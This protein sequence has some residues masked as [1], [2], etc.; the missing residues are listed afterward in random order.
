VNKKSNLKGV[1]RAKILAISAVLSVVAT[2]C[3]PLTD[4]SV[5]TSSVSAKMEAPATISVPTQVAKVEEPASRST[6]RVA[7]SSYL[8]RAPYICTPSG[9]GQTSRCFLR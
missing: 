8:G 4:S 5:V 3:T 6:V 9:F 2:G 1:G 7:S